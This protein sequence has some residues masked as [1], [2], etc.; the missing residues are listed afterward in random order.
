MIEETIEAVKQA[1]AKAK[2]NVANA[3]EK[4]K[5]IE[6]SAASEIESLREKAKTS[7]REAYDLAMEEAKKERDN[8]LFESSKKSEE[9]IKELKDK[10]APEVSSA[11]EAVV[12]YVL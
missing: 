12:A 8:I 1:E 9:A 2:E 5:E 3:R 11:V 10:A 7:D 4:S 6:G